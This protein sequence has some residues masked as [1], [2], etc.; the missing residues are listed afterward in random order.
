M[1]TKG[2]RIIL[3][4]MVP[5][6]K[7][8]TRKPLQLKHLCLGR[9][10]LQCSTEQN[11]SPQHAAQAIICL[12]DVKKISPSRTVF[13]P[14]A[15]V[16]F[17]SIV[18][19]VAHNRRVLADTALTAVLVALKRLCVTSHTAAYNAL[20]QEA[21]QRCR[22]F[23]LQSLSRFLVSLDQSSNV[24][25]SYQCKAMERLQAL[26]PRCYTDE[27]VKCAAISLLRVSRLASPDFVDAFGKKTLDVLT[28]VSDFHTVLRCL[29]VLAKRQS[30]SKS[31]S[32]MCRL[33]SLINPA[34]SRFD[35]QDLSSLASNFILRGDDVP[36]TLSLIRERAKTL[37][38]EEPS[39]S[40]A[41]CLAI[42]SYSA[43]KQVEECLL[44]LLEN[45]A[46]EWDLTKLLDVVLLLPVEDKAVLTLFWEKVAAVLAS[47]RSAQTIIRGYVVCFAKT[48][49]RHKRFEEEGL[50]WSLS[51]LDSRCFYPRTVSLATLFVSAFGRLSSE[52][53]A[54]VVSMLPQLT[55]LL[56]RDVARGIYLSKQR[57]CGTLEE[58]LHK[59]FRRRVSTTESWKEINILMM[60]EK[61]LSATG[62][63]KEGIINSYRAQVNQ[64]PPNSVGIFCKLMAAERFWLPDVYDA[65][66]L[67][68]LEEE[69]LLGPVGISNLLFACFQSGY[70][71]HRLDAVASTANEQLLRNFDDMQETVLLQAAIA[72]G[73]FQSL[74][75]ALIKH[76]FSVAFMDRLD[77]QLAGLSALSR[78]QL[79][80]L[81]STLN[82]IVCLDF[83]EEGV[84]WFHQHYYQNHIATVSHRLQPIQREVLEV[85]VHLLSGMD[86]VR[87]HVYTPYYY[88]ISFECVL[89]NNGRPV[90]CSDYGSVLW[91]CDPALDERH[92]KI[93]SSLPPEYQRVAIDVLREPSFC[94]NVPH[95]AGYQLL[96]NRH[97]EILGY[98]L[99]Q[100][101]FFEWNSMRLSDR[102]SR[103]AYLQAKIFAP[104]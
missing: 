29:P 42:S 90:P 57:T 73:F 30:S 6:I 47:S 48:G 9:E 51:Q 19:Q 11:L 82:R 21:S 45:A 91:G 97:L 22:N 84:P 85:L 52:H 81:L 17:E 53:A 18:S 33:L 74:G 88:H 77:K 96:K 80:E 79:R 98:K 99:V 13:D 2:E 46:D 12:W 62:G 24:S 63:L 25:L 67:R 59:E 104:T 92:A 37:F 102:H 75:S 5:C 66:V 10:I 54:H 70:A 7:S 83:P 58:S 93:S 20:I 44:P 71:P 26:L 43:V 1:S 103:A 61:L 14:A 35:S 89:D 55:P 31:R 28:P 72:L 87:C 41:R 64:A 15:L 56:L 100:V 95:M 16:G 50:K 34:I 86:H 68:V 27:D 94:D 8:Y 39:A 101:P 40:L 65:L 36:D 38:F 23:D 4:S 32:Y 3:A 78:H 49:F 60:T 76:I 69:N